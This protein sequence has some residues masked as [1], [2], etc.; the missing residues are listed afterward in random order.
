[1]IR[2]VY[3]LAH[4]PYD[5][6]ISFYTISRHSMNECESVNIVTALV[7]KQ[8][9]SVYHSAPSEGSGVQQLKSEIMAKLFYNKC[10]IP[11]VV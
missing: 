5:E 4:Y 8:S 9:W 1:M 6:F 10:I 2:V 3:R 11:T 7:N